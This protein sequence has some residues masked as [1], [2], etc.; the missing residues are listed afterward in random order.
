MFSWFKFLYVFCAIGLL[1]FYS[2]KLFSQQKM[3]NDTIQ[4]VQVALKTLNIGDVRNGGSH[5]I[6]KQDVVNE[7]ILEIVKVQ[8]N[9]GKDIRISYVFLNRDNKSTENENEIVGIQ[10]KVELLNNKGEVESI[11]EQRQILKRDHDE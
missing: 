5:S 10:F 9:H 8:K 6:S 1:I 7:L 11:S 4:N 2:N 3:N